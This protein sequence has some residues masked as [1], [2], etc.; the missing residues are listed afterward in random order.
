MVATPER[1]QVGAKKDV[2]AKLTEKFYLR[3]AADLMRYKP[4]DVVHKIAPRALLMTTV[5]RDVVTP[6]DHAE[7]LYARAGAPKRLIRQ[8]ETS[9]YRSY[10]ENYP[11]LLP[12]I[13][14]W[15]DTYLKYTP[16]ESKETDR[17]EEVVWLER[18]APAR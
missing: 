15:Y 12:E 18:K 6:E 7:S 1:G 9:H 14:A 4:I 10:V 11:A 5:E 16:L 13:V 8:T 17:T 3:T 2:D